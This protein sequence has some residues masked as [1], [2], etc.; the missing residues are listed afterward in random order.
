M[1]DGVPNQVEKE[2]RSYLKCGMT[3]ASLRRASGS[4]LRV[5]SEHRG[6]RV[7]AHGFTRA[8]CSCCGYDSLVA[9]SC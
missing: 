4:P 1:G 6:R 5:S 2:F 3:S 8:R 9:S 7:L